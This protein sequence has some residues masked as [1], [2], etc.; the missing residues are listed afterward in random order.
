ME[1]PSIDDSSL[2]GYSLDDKSAASVP[3]EELNS[4]FK[5]LRVR[6]ER[7]HGLA[8]KD[9]FGFSDPYVTLE[10][11]QSGGHVV[12]SVKTK[13]IKKTL[14]PVWKEEWIFRVRNTFVHTLA[15]HVFDE[16]RVTR[17]D[18]LGQIE[19]PLDSKI[20]TEKRSRPIV[21]KGHTLK[22]RSQKSKV[23]GKITVYV[24]YLPNRRSAESRES[25]R[26]RRAQ[27]SPSESNSTD[28]SGLENVSGAESAVSFDDVERIDSTPT[29]SISESASGSTL[30][31]EDIERVG[32]DMEDFMAGLTLPEGWEERCDGNGRTF[33]VNHETRRTQ[34]EH[35]QMTMA[36]GGASEEVRQTRQHISVENDE[37]ENVAASTDAVVDEL[38]NANQ[39]ERRGSK[40]SSKPSLK[41]GKDKLPDGWAQKVAPNGRVFFI[42]HKEKTTTWVDPRTDKETPVPTGARGK[43]GQRNLTNDGLGPL[44]PGWEERRHKD[45]RTFFIDHNNKKTQWEDPRF[46]D[47]AV[48]GAAIPY[49]R[50]YKWKYDYMKTQLPKA[51]THAREF[52]IKIRRRHIFEDSF[53]ALQMSGKHAPVLR[54]KLNI[55]FDHEKGKKET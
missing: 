17:D 21:A 30:N 40:S 13:T 11:K 43:S 1:I 39:N 34:W 38:A 22:Q 48:A 54:C 15:F 41:M 47:S 6:I 31:T 20:P 52:P 23:K 10:L 14:D 32:H 29:E 51:P 37:N 3:T 28:F 16:N 24:A 2:R 55:E 26:R 33:Y 53:R 45:G 4:A 44:P 18:F 12:D 8:K 42:N 36:V 25:N 5:L 49:S 35:P 9:L 27:L 7:A 19:I 50:D 46:N